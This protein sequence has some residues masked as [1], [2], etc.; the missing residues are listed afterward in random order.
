M[1]LTI[2][3]ADL[4]DPADCSGLV[5]VL[6]SYASDPVGGGEPLVQM[7]AHGFQSA[8]GIILRRW[9]CLP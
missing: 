3:Q 6:N 4:H 5:D 2:R 7:F 1:D 9:Y 8:C